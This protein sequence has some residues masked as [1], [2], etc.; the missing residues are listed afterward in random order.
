MSVYLRPLAQLRF[1]LGIAARPAELSTDSFSTA[2]GDGGTARG[3]GYHSGGRRLRSEPLGGDLLRHRRRFYFDPARQCGCR[4]RCCHLQHAVLV[5]GG[6]FVGID[7]FGQGECSFKCSV[8]NLFVMQIGMVAIRWP[9]GASGLA[10]RTRLVLHW[11]F[12]GDY[13][14]RRQP[15]NKSSSS[16]ENISWTSTVN[17]ANERSGNAG[18]IVTVFWGRVTGLARSAST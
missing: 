1:F 2:G 13:Q 9:R 18:R 11:P 3:Q 7:A 5:F 4:H 12:D 15:R 14:N 8:G 10:S 6:Q 17:S 16:A